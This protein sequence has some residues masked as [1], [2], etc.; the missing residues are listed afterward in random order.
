MYY[1]LCSLIIASMISVPSCCEGRLSQIMGM[2]LS[3]WPASSHGLRS[4][5]CIRYKTYPVPLN[6]ACS[7]YNIIGGIMHGQWQAFHS[8]GRSAFTVLTTT[9]MQTD[10]CT[11]ARRGR[12][13]NRIVW[14]SLSVTPRHLEWPVT[15]HDTLTRIVTVCNQTSHIP[16]YHTAPASYLIMT[17]RV[18]LGVG[19]GVNVKP[20]DNTSTLLMFIKVACSTYNYM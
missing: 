14:I 20:L 18:G 10:H 4:I 12:G 2:R 19:E 13:D 11:L 8:N 17:L 1:S 15:L 16:Y 6:T 5:M 7:W 3:D 9:D